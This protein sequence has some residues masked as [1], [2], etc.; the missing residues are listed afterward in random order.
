MKVKKIPMRMC[1]GCMEMKPKKELIRVVK[2]KEGEISLDLVGKKPGRGA[3][4][5]KSTDCL[6]KAFKTKR[7]S[8]NLETTISQEIYDDLRKAVEVG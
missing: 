2:N 3:Y 1:T 5:C 6:E 4:V 7:L 8:R